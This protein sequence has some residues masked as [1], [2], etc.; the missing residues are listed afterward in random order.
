MIAIRWGKDRGKTRLGWLDSAHTFSFN[1]YYDPEYTGFSDLLV[2]NDDV[3][4]AGQGF[5]TH[6]HRDM[7]IV[8][9]VL[10]GAIEHK[11]STGTGAILVPG[12]VQRMTAGSGVSHSEFNPSK[13]ERL[14]FLQIW[15][16]PERNGLPPGYEQKAF[17]ESE[18]SGRLRLVA[19]RD[20]REGS[21]TIHQDAAM[22][23]TRLGE[24]KGVTHVLPA[25]RR[26][27]VH[28][29]KGAANLNENALSAGD[30]AGVVDERKLEIWSGAGAEVLLFELR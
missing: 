29:A 13:T 16:T 27:W 25:G 30:G 14:H 7:E 24:G 1:R 20:G 12:E 26:A 19:S 9:Y 3:V 6:S 28:V 8:S 4:E 21:L 23:V 15:I 2:L 17:A 22:Y 5:G 11:D 18:L 10:S